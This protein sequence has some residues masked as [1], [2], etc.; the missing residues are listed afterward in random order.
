MRL[1]AGFIILCGFMTARAQQ[2]CAAVDHVPA[3]PCDQADFQRR[4]LFLQNMTILGHR[5]FTAEDALTGSPRS[6]DIIAGRQV[7]MGCGDTGE[8]VIA[9]HTKVYPKRWSADP[10]VHKGDEVVPYNQNGYV[11]KALRNGRTSNE[12]GAATYKDATTEGFT[13]SGHVTGV[14]LSS[15]G[16]GYT[17]PPTVRFSGNGGAIANAIIHNGSVVHVDVVNCGSG[18][19]SPPTIT[20]D[21]GGGE[22]A[23][24]RSSISWFAHSDE[25]DWEVAR[26]ALTRMW[27]PDMEIAPYLAVRPNNESFSA[28]VDPVFHVASL[29]GKSSLREPSWTGV[30]VDSTILWETQWTY[31]EGYPWSHFAGRKPRGWEYPAVAYGGDVVAAEGRIFRVRHFSSSSMHQTEPRWSDIPIDGSEFKDANGITWACIGLD[32]PN[33]KTWHPDSLYPV[34]TLIRPS[35]VLPEDGRRLWFA[36][37]ITIRTGS[38]QPNWSSGDTLLEL[39]GNGTITWARVGIDGADVDFRASRR[40]ILRDGFRAEDGSRFHA[41]IKPSTD[42]NSTSAWTERFLY[43]GL[44]DLDSVWVREEGSHDNRNIYSIPEQVE[45][46]QNDRGGKMLRLRADY[47]PMTLTIDSIPYRHSLQVSSVHT[48]RRFDPFSIFEAKLRTPTSLGCFTSFWLHSHCAEHCEPTLHDGSFDEIDIYERANWYPGIWQGHQCD[49][50]TLQSAH[51]YGHNPLSTILVSSTDVYSGV[52]LSADFHTFTFERLPGVMRWLVD[53]KVVKRLPEKNGLDFPRHGTNRQAQ[54]LFH[55]RSYPR[56]DTN[57]H[58]AFDIEY[59][60][61]TPFK[62][63]E[64]DGN[65]NVIWGNAVVNFVVTPNPTNSGRIEFEM[66]ADVEV[67]NLQITIFDLLGNEVA[68]DF[69]ASVGKSWYGKYD[70][71]ASLANGMYFVHL[72]A[73]AAQGN[74][75][76]TRQ[77]S[78]QR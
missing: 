13:T 4:T 75:R 43:T 40:V 48:K 25:M 49:G 5:L 55:N 68:Y 52:D 28:D 60:K 29:S 12:W 18:Y 63:L 50:Y 15:G 58:S 9:R 22:G 74:I 2:P 53:G 42:D 62:S 10:T 33:P 19:T 36:K 77:V 35:A 57:Y 34:G 1:L 45:L 70:F 54:I 51:N 73:D 56:C 7:I 20:F 44:S 72:S 41:Y 59:V 14:T 17:S 32:A 8:V 16:S 69:N 11:Y 66:T 61:V 46:V 27:F 71:P 24:A 78:L 65:E 6:S 39:T 64:E 67:N 21:G 37:T 26:P 76:V 47:E 38:S 30:H 3:P 31:Y 23:I